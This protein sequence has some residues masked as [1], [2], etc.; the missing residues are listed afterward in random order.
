MKKAL[1]LSILIVLL[2]PGCTRNEWGLDAKAIPPDLGPMPEGLVR[3]DAPPDIQL[4][5]LWTPP[6]DNGKEVQARDTVHNPDTGQDTTPPQVVSAFSTDGKSVTVRFS[7][8]VDPKT[9]GSKQNYDIVGSDS[10]HIAVT[11]AQ[12]NNVFVKLALDPNAHIDPELTYKVWVSNVTDLAGN[13][14]DPQAHKAVITRTVYVAILWHQHQPLYLDPAK[15]ELE[16]PWVRKHGVKDYYPMARLIKDYPDVHLTINLTAVMLNQLITYYLDRLSPFLDKKKDRIDTQAFF[17]KWKG[18]TDPWVDLLLEPTPDPLGQKGPKPTDQQIELFYDGPWSCLSTSDALMS[19]FP[20]Y[21]ELRQKNPLTYTYDDL[22]N[23]KIY[24]ELAWFH[25]MFLRG[26]VKL[27]DG[28]VVDLTDVVKRDQAGKFT[29]AVPPSDDLANRLLA[30]EVKILNNI[31]PIHKSLRYDPVAHTGQVELTTT[32]YYHPILPLL[33][34][35]DSARENQPFDKLP[36]PPFAFPQ[37]ANAQV[38]MA[39]RF[40]QDLFGAKPLGMWPGEGSVSEAAISAFVNNGIKWVATDQQVL[41]ESLGGSLPPFAQYQPYMVDTDTVKGQAGPSDRKMAIFFRDT[42]LSNKVGFTFQPM[43][44]QVSAGE[45]LKDVARMA[46]KFGGGDRL[47]VMIMDGEN[48]WESYT[49]TMDGEGFLRALYKDLEDGFRVGEVVPVTMSEYIL[50]N[51]KRNVPPHPIDSLKELEPLSAGSWI[52]GNFAIWIG[53]PEENLGWDYLRRAR[54]D[55]QNSGLQQPDPTLEP[56]KPAENAKY[57]TFKAYDEIYAAEGSDWFWWFGSDMES[58]SHDDTP[59]DRGFRAHLTGMYDAANKALGMLGKPLMNVPDFPPIIQAKAQSPGGPFTTPPTIDG[60]FVPNESE[61]LSDGGTFFDNDSGAIANPLD[62]MAQIYYGYDSTGFYVAIVL[63]RD[64]TAIGTPFQVD[65]LVNQKHI[66]DAQ[67]GQFT[68]NPYSQ[69]DPF[70]NDLGFVTGGAAWDVRLTYNGGAPQVS[71]LA[72]DS[73][74][75]FKPTDASGI[76]AAGPVN[77]SKLIEMKLPW[78]VLQMA[79]G[80]PLEFMVET[81]K[82]GSLRDKAP[83][84]GGKLVFEDVTRLVYVTFQVDVSGKTTPIDTYGPINNP[85]PPAGKGIVMIAGNQDKLGAWIPNKIPLRDD[86]KGGDKVAGDQVWTGVFGFMPGTLI[87]YKY[88]IGT[89]KDKARWSGT[90]EFPLTERG[91]TV[92]KDPDCHKMVIKDIFADRPQPTGTM[93]PHSTLDK[94][95]K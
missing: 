93:G 3:S 85:P 15:D 87:R 31:I 49:K 48:A 89:P 58:P 23:L 36:K 74:G 40:Y 71:L 86:G 61:W 8:P 76:L 13:V 91:F 16:G 33:V 1:F 29:L 63:N 26:P 62:D 12:V 65:V 43:W 21:Q 68:Q 25:P 70:G 39:V 14:V 77:H 83:N 55:L 28:S 45:F 56:P 9:G 78:S 38:A 69:K 79:M 4:P 73:S 18:H 67:T 50:G 95:A 92:T 84:L 46:P 10:S 53:E 5:D 11:Q 24:F 72:A 19:F 17:A 60:K 52:G 51:P 37:D 88:T 64:I 57:Y 90:E 42:A 20:K 81:S 34:S 82:S 44:G 66:L 27:E 41:Q 22:L 47:M 54:T 75:T 7:E 30:E 59:F 2:I 80:D 32:P 6:A 94:C 35:T